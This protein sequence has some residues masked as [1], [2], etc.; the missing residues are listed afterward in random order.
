MLVTL[1][2]TANHRHCTLIMT[3]ALNDGATFGNDKDISKVLLKQA[4]LKQ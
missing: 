2:T 1:L 3:P 4:D